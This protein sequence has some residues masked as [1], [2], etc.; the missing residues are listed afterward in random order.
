MHQITD[1]LS[2]ANNIKRK[3]NDDSNNNNK[4]V[5]VTASVKTKEMGKGINV[6]K[7]VY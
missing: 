2:D 5:G 7:I 3:A 6:C 1:F 4:C